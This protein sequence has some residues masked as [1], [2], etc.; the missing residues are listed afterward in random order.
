MVIEL[1]ATLQKKME[2]AAQR[3][4]IEVEKLV[5]QILES[6][7]RYEYHSE[8]VKEAHRRLLEYDKYKKEPVDDLIA[9]VRAAKAEA[10]RLYK[11]N[12]EWFDLI[13]R[14]GSEHG[15]GWTGEPEL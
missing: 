13:A 14:K 6:H 8:R 7:L 3:Q 5:M 1:P 2:Y 9:A 10:Y 11:D 15:P 4:G 12:E